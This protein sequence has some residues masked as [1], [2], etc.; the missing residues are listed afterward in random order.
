[1]S[2]PVRSGIRRVLA[3]F[4]V[5]SIPALGLAQTDDPSTFFIENQGQR[6]AFVD[7]E[8]IEPGGYRIAVIDHGFEISPDSRSVNAGRS[9]IRVA[10]HSATRVP[11]RAAEKLDGSVLFWFSKDIDQPVAGAGRFA[12]I[13]LDEL[14]PGIDARYETRPGQF[15]RRLEIA[16][17]ADLSKVELRYRAGESIERL[18]DGSLLVGDAIERRPVAKLASGR[19]YPVD[20]YEVEP[21]TYSLRAPSTLAG[22]SYAIEFV[23]DYPDWLPQTASRLARLADHPNLL[24]QVKAARPGDLLVFETGSRPVPPA[25]P[26]QPVTEPRGGAIVGGDYGCSSIVFANG[27][28]IDPSVPFTNVGGFM[29]PPG[30]TVSV[31]GGTS[32]PLDVTAAGVLIQGTLTASGAGEAGGA[33]VTGPNANGNTG[34]GLGPGV[35]GT[36]AG[37]FSD[38]SGGGGGAYGGDGGRGGVDSGSPAPAPGGSAYGA[39]LPPGIEFGSGGGSGAAVGAVPSGGGGRGGGIVDLLANDIRIVGILA[40]DGF[41]GGPG[42]QSGDES[43]AGGG[44]GGGGIVVESSRNTLGS[45]SVLARGGGGGGGV[46]FGGYGGGGGGGRIKFLGALDPSAGLATNVNGG[47]A[48]G[49][50]SQSATGGAP[51]T[52]DTS[53]TIAPNPG[54]ADVTTC[55]ITITERLVTQVDSTDPVVAG[56]QL[57]YTVNVTNDGPGPET[58]AVATT[59]LDPAVTLVSTSGCAEDP[60]GAPTC[61]IGAVAPGTTSSFTIT[62]DV[63]SDYTGSLS[64][65]VTVGGA[66]VDPIP[67]NDQAIEPTGV[68]AEADLAVSKADNVDPAVAGTN[69]TYTVTVDN[70]GPS[71]ATDVV[72]T[73][74]LPP[75][76][77]LV[78][79]SGCAEDPTG[80]PNCSLGTIAAGGQASYTLTAAID[81]SVVGV[82]TNSVSVTSSTTD[83]DGTNNSFDE[84]TTVVAEADLALTKTDSPDPVIAGNTITYTLTVDNPGPS[85]ATGV[86]VNDSLPAGVTLVS[87]SGCAEDPGGVPNCSLGTVPAGGSATYTILGQVASSVVGT[88]MNSATVSS[89]ATDP[90]PGNDTATAATTVVA[91]ADMS[92]A[93][94]GP[95]TAT[96]GTQV[97]YGITVT[98]NGPSDASSVAVADPTPAGYTFV[99]ATGACAGGF[100]CALGAMGAGASVAFDVT[101]DIDP[102]IGGTSV[103]NTATVSTATTDPN[104]A[105]DES[106]ATTTIEAEADLGVTKTGPGTATAGGMPVTYT[107]TVTNNGPSDAETV[108]L[109]DPTPAGFTFASATAPCAGGFPCALGTMVPSDVISVDVTFDIDPAT[110]GDVTNTATVSSPTVDPNAANDSASVTTTVS[111]EADLSIVK[112]VDNNAIQQGESVVYTLSVTNAGPSDADN[113]VITDDLPEGQVLVSTSGC[114]EDPSGAPTCSIGT[115]AAGSTVAVTLTAQ[116]QRANGV[117]T[118]T[119]S[120]ASD[121][122]DPDGANNAGSVIVIASLSIPVLGAWGLIALVLML[123]AV[124]GL[125]VR[126]MI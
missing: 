54:G 74:T 24:D 85:D 27:D 13:E 113:V 65:T 56:T 70:F 110:T 109:D 48:N 47:G 119:A 5:A 121:T 105:N 52:V 68:I 62:V 21:G 73:D 124:G 86:V 44:G 81:P 6:Q 59:T 96:A 50:D 57:T 51:G 79:T 1:M 4:L 46:F 23:L 87:T 108:S 115:V 30:V 120:V 3:A 22:R 33:T 61:T 98:N 49:S 17:G 117:Q 76:F 93:K 40:A 84:T 126:R 99:S 92:I 111:G 31:L 91:E 2:I 8:V 107:L 25:L 95:A 16:P 90:N 34:S 123:M 100:P 66:N 89:S 38:Q 45:G 77:T 80:A 32:A 20:F 55:G 101:Y 69:V 42:N 58:A 15:I 103:S 43:S 88:I 118:N 64:N 116:V 71:D 9:A 97:T 41:G 67:A 7:Y 60:V 19:T 78:S 36:Q 11:F 28:V 14:Y 18:A 106:T 10:F 94:S 29:V 12:G 39:A 82:V 112:T 63:P 83:P 26:E 53:T 125:Q 72:V 104:A 35:G 122:A 75:G 114:F 102:S 37:F